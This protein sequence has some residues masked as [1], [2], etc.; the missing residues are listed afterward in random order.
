MISI[1]V[2]TDY[3]IDILNLIAGYREMSKRVKKS[4]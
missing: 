2:A 3:A 1:G 4:N